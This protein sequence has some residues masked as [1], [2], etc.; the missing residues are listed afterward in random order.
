MEFSRIY[1]QWT[2]ILGSSF[3]MIAFQNCAKA[4]ASSNA[5][6]GTSSGVT[7]LGATSSYS[8]VTYDP[9]LEG[10]T[11]A[12]AQHLD[13]DLDAGTVA[14]GG[15]TCQLDVSRGQ[16]LKALLSVGRVCQPDHSQ[17]PTGV[18]NCLAISLADIKL[19]DSSGAESVLLNKVTCGNGTYLCDGDDAELRSIIADLIAHPVITNCQ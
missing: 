4:P 8:K 3:L 7:V 11:G 14:S 17:D 6:G 13:I 16:R 12:V 15:K 10:R 2:L 18:V 9:N 5:L 1:R 19:A